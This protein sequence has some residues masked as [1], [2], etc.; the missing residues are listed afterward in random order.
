MERSALFIMIEG[1]HTKYG[2][3]SADYSY[4]IISEKRILFEAM[5]HETLDFSKAYQK[6]DDVVVGYCVAIQKCTSCLLAWLTKS[7]EQRK[8]STTVASF[9][10]W[11]TENAASLTATKNETARHKCYDAAGGRTCVNGP[12]VRNSTN[13][14][15]MT[16]DTCAIFILV[17]GRWRIYI[18]RITH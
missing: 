4:G 8:R 16:L 7:D 9:Q 18:L 2:I 11:A 15:G 13:A 1:L 5:R 3:F 10:S 14:Y 6:L 17:C 12:H